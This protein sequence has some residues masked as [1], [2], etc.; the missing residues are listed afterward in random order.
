MVVL[1][2]VKGLTQKKNSAILDGSNNILKD[3]GYGVEWKILDTKENG[4]PHSR[5]RL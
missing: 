2:N 1:E 5:P 3:V 4:I